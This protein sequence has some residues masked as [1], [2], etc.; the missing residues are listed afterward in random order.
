MLSAR[1]L[2]V[3]PADWQSVG[4]ALQARVSETW[5]KRFQ[6]LGEAQAQHRDGQAGKVQAAW[7]LHRMID[8]IEIAFA[9][10]VRGKR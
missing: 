7:R 6:H 8:L 3:D 2:R 10:H 4:S 5:P 9:E 1:D